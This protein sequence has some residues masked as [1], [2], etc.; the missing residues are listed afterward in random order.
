MVLKRTCRHAVLANSKALELAGITKDTANPEGG[1]IERDENGEVTGYLH[2]G[3]QDLVL[4]LL[5]E[6]TVESLTKALTKS[7]DDLVALGLTGAVTDDLGYYGDYTNPLQAF[8]NVIGRT[9][10]ISC[11]FTKKI[12]GIRTNN[13][14]EGNLRRTLDYAR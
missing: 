12:S 6:P 3:A 5:P 4:N 13:G 7:V 10:K 9:A 8:K 1:V 11:S 14:R 2:E